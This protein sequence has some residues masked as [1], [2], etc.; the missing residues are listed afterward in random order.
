MSQ[1]WN[2]VIGLTLLEVSF[3]G[4]VFIIAVVLIR[5]ITI[6]RLPK[7][8]FLVLWEMVLL[9]L[10]IP[11]AIPSAF[12]IYTLVNHSL[13]MPAFFTVSYLRCR[14]EFPHP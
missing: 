10:I 9:R 5:A 4:A 13:P 8:T 7:K 11:F 2:E 6:H 1:I 12:S 14:I 3:S